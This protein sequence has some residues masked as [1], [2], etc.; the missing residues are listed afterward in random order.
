MLALSPAVAVSLLPWRCWWPAPVV[1]VKPA[2]PV[3]KK[4][5][6]AEKWVTIRG[7]IVGDMTKGEPPTKKRDQADKGRGHHR[8]EG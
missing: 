4:D 8:T 6:E 5:F 2:A 7:R 3:V 1:E